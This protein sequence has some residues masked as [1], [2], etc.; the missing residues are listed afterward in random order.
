MHER[1]HR[2]FGLDLL[3]AIAILTVVYSHGGHFFQN[4]AYGYRYDYFSF[5]GVSF[6]FVLSGFLIGRILIRSV[7]SSSFNMATL[8]NFWS[9]RWFRTLPNYFLVL[10]LLIGGY[11]ILGL[12]IDANLYPYFL[13]AQNIASPH[14]DFFPE[15]WSLAVEEWFYLGFPLVLYAVTKGKIS[16]RS[17]IALSI[18]AF[19]VLITLLRAYKASQLGLTDL[20]QWDLV[21]RKQVVTRLDSMLYGVGGAYLSM[22]HSTL[23]LRFK[24]PAFCLGLAIILIDKLLYGSAFYRNYFCFTAVAVGILCLLPKLSI[25]TRESGGVVTRFV[26][27]ISV[28]SYAMYLLNLTVVQALGGEIVKRLWPDPDLH[29]M[30]QYVIYWAMTIGLS[31]ALYYFFERHMTDLRDRWRP[32]PRRSIS[33]QPTDG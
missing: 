1:Q 25:W 18:C 27:F 14:P 11:S 7:D 15:A 13:F 16:K 33:A 24:N 20:H 21:F 8:L 17:M 22:Y 12:P 29:P 32:P 23:W 5:D 30:L 2:V 9:R 6:F 4:Y 26:T 19:I 3:R 10:L 31:Y 28:I